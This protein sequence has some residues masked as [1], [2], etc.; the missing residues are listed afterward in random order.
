MNK[1]LLFTSIAL[2]GTLVSLA[3]WQSDVRLTNDPSDSNTS[4]NN[5]WCVASS[6]DTVHVVWDDQ[7]DGNYEIY[8]KYSTDAGLS[9]GSDTRLTNNTSYS[10]DPCVAVAGQ[11][12]HVVWQN[13]QGGFYE[14]FYKHSIDGGLNWSA[15]TSLTNVAA[16]LWNP[17]IALNGSAVHLV[18]EDERQGNSEIYYK[19]S[20]DGGLNWGA[21]IRLTV[22]VADSWNPSV[23]VFGSVVHVVWYDFRDGNWEIYYKQS[24][25]GGLTWGADIRMTTNTSVSRYPCVAVSGSV[26]HVLWHDDRD[27]SYQTY[28]KRSNDGGASWGLDTRLSTGTG[29]SFYPCLAVS[30]S[31]VHAVWFDQRDG[32]YEIYYKNSM[33]GGISWGPDVRLTNEPAFSFYPSVAVSGSFVHVV[34]KDMR[35]GNYEI[36]YKRDSTGNS[37]G[38]SEISFNENT[39]QIYPNPFINEITIKNNKIES[40]EI[41]IYDLTSREILHTNFS[42]TMTL[43]TADFARG[44]YILEV[45]NSDAILMKCKIIKQ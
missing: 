6:G 41:I 44:I 40:A 29:G 33:D 43:N 38:V 3:Q 1:K 10:Y 4:L 5:A 30:G 19:S 2:L 14:I 27:G 12:V 21:D 22:D 8:Y 36:Y 20:M 15:D 39:F 31:Y 35:D 25:D 26:V 18:W 42:N 24:T 17:S 28:Y 32:N 37:V 13:E 7:R 45:R 9:W 11:D 34:W 16:D 23:A